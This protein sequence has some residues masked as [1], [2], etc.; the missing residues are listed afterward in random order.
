MKVLVSDP[1]AQEGID[2]LKEAGI[3]VEVRTGMPPEELL[4]AV[5][6]I[7]GL[8]IRSSTKVTKEVVAAAKHLK[9]VG[10]AGSGLDN[11]DIPACNARGVVVMNTPGGNTNSAAE[12]TIAM[13][14]AVSRHIPQATASMKAGKWEKKRF[15]GQ[16]VRGK[17][18][19]IIG[20]GRIGSI[21]AQSAQGL[22][23]RVIAY[24]PHILPEAADRIGVEVMSLDDLL[25]RADY[26]SIHTPLTP[27][28]KGMV[29]AAAFA[30]MKKGAVV[31][32]CARGG[33][34]NEA[35]LDEALASGK[36]FGA[37][38]DVFEK[39]PTT[40][41]HP[42]LARDNFICT[43]HLGA[44]TREA[45]E[46]VATAVARQIADYLTRGEIRNAVNV[47]SVSAEAMA[48]LG[49][50]LVLAERLGLF[51]A[52]LA[53]GPVEEVTIA[54]SGE[55]ADLD[56]TPVSIAVV[57]GLLT[58]ALREEVN[59]VNARI[60]AHERGIKITESK[61]VT[62][63]D[64]MN[65][66]AV[67]VKAADGKNL[68][69]GTIFGKKEPRIVRIND[70]RLEAVPE[71]NMLLIQNDDRP[72]VIGR[73]GTALGEYGINIARMQVGQDPDRRKNVMLITTDGPVTQEALAHLMKQD[74]VTNARI[75]VL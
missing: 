4:S 68:V 10:R 18:L 29:N 50:F 3:E 63:E 41:E 46:N 9:V 17:T 48:K 26:I 16:E 37:A 11:V 35:D 54:Y 58:P 56:T 23:M 32:S 19:G 65:L 67:T 47:P 36:L 52:Q 34:V 30:K 59:F 69:A 2:I 40:K 74:G 71:G 75:L 1:I 66:L 55:M 64:Y 27:E 43:P 49:P 33:I 28:T 7:D 62:S 31:I 45:Q 42:L 6:D 53:T 39:E 5:A 14:L 22:G 25:A 73:I 20:I 38:L 57:K 24:D 8:V 15:M 44:S 51:H 12:H 60:L 61:S 70:F 13:M 21:V 72:G